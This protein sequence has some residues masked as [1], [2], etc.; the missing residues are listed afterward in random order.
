MKRDWM[1]PKDYFERIVKPTVEDYWADRS[2]HRK[3]NAVFQLSSFSE[4]YFKYHKTKGNGARVF[5]A[6]GAKRFGEEVSKRCLEYGLLWDAANGVKHHF[7]DGRT[8][9]GAMETTSTG[10]WDTKEYEVFGRWVTIEQAI[11]IVYEY[12]RKLLDAES[13]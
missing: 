11:G 6:A 2:D 13:E 12:W 1:T 3:E 8:R 7:P 4:R 5:G 10:V 9:A